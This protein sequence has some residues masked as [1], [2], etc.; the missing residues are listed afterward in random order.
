MDILAKAGYLDM[1][2]FLAKM[3][4]ASNLRRIMGVTSVHILAFKGTS[5]KKI[6]KEETNRKLAKLVNSFVY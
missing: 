6:Y 1:D 5:P 3:H 4:I 2:I